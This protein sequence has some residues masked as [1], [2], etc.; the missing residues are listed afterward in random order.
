[1]G[2]KVV[3]DHPEII[4][5]YQTGLSAAAVAKQ[6]GC[7]KPGVI[8]VLRSNGVLRRGAKRGDTERHLGF[9]PTKKWMRGEV[10]VAG[11]A[12]EAA[13]RNGINYRTWIDWMVRLGIAREVWHGGPGGKTR[14]QEI[15]TKEAIKLSEE[16]H[17]Y[18]E[19]AAKYGVSY[20]V[21]VRRMADADYK[22]PRDRMRKHPADAP[23]ANAPWAHRKIM[24]ELGITK[25]EICGEDRAL[26]FCHIVS[27]KNGGP[28]TKEN[29][30]VLCPLHH[31]LYDTDKL[32][33]GESASICRKVRKAKKLYGVY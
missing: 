9:R 13:R 4:R 5:L 12:A 18:R 16:G 7:S 19:L 21:I 26:D 22:A 32:D 28:T 30:L 27:L 33:V 15:P 11:T 20:G 31:R 29:C 24:H 8:A 17:T 2:H 1:M 3:L 6:V 23:Y 10:K 14:R 25:C